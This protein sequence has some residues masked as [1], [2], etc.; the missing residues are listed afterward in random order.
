MTK[1]RL[2]SVVLLVMLLLPGLVLA[3]EGETQAGGLPPTGFERVCNSDPYTGGLARC[4]NG[5]YVL[6]LGLGGLFAVLMIIIAGYKYMTAQGNSQQVENAKES[7]ASAFIG[8]IVLFIAFVLLNGINPDL[9]RFRQFSDITGSLAIPQDVKITVTVAAD[10]PL[11]AVQ[12]GASLR[13]NWSSQGAQRCEGAEGLAGK[14]VSGTSGSV[15]SGPILET[16]IFTVNCFATN[17]AG[18]TFAGQGFYRIT[19]R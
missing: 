19:V 5:I 12:S 2:A 18:A 9:V 4:I 3:A 15:D 11:H 8:L 16:T 14:G 6:S 10:P 1:L 7:F 13:I 17:N